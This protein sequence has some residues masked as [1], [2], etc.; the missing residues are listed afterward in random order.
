M[1]QI[2]H[3]GLRSFSSICRLNSNREITL[4]PVLE[5]PPEA[6]QYSAI[7]EELSQCVWLEKTSFVVTVV[8]SAGVLARDD[9][10]R[11]IP[12]LVSGSW[13]YRRGGG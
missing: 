5:P 10:E 7:S 2:G 6:C 1:G 12:E 9:N 3:S 13:R 4:N 8:C 11:G